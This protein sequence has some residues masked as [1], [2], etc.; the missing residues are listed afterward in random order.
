MDIQE[1]DVPDRSLI[2]QFAAREGYYTDCFVA[3]GAQSDLCGY[4]EAFYTQ[5]L[6][7]AERLLLRVAA[8]ARSTD[9]EAAAL[10]RGEIDRFAV[11][12]VSAR[13]DTE[14]L[15]VDASGRTMSWL[16]VADGLSFGSVVTPVRDRRGR[17]TLGP[18]FHSLL[19]AHRIYARA[20][21]AGAARRLRHRGS[22]GR[23]L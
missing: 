17:L 9:D 6:F 7:K 8:G 18:V 21:L 12:H 2:A 15:M 16:S 10:A 5:P 19:S 1:A 14:L 4:I 3:H 22:Q 23:F 13:T 11:W 20:L